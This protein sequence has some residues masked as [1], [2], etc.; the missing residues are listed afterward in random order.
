M[1]ENSG[2]ETANKAPRKVTIDGKEYDFDSLNEVARNQLGNLRMA[3]QRIAQLQADVALAQ[4][5][6]TV[7]AKLLGENLPKD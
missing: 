3:D 7:F 6:R 1:A 4:T 2:K 5:A